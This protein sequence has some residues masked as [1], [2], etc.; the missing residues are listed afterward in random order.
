[1]E[2][3]FINEYE[4]ETYKHTWWSTLR[5]TVTFKWREVALST[6]LENMYDVLEQRAEF[7]DIGRTVEGKH[8]EER[9]QEVLTLFSGQSSKK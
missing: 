1:M 8:Y 6:H 5:L 4:I 2:L 7:V 9:E 3:W